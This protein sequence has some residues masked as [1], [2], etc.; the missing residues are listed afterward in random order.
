MEFTEP[1]VENLGF[2]GWAQRLRPSSEKHGNLG[3]YMP[4]DTQWN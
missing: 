1:V 2:A 3:I 4:A